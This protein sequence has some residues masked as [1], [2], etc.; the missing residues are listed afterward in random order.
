[1]KTIQKL[2]VL[3]LIIFGFIALIFPKESALLTKEKGKSYECACVGL[4]SWEI[5][6]E[7]DLR[8]A[9]CFG[10]IHSCVKK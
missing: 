5:S 1:M 4:N 8:F 10:I 9:T 6:P 3:F 7:M 2:F